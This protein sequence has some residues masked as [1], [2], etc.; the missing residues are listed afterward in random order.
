MIRYSINIIKPLIFCFLLGINLWFFSCSSFEREDPSVYSGGVAITL[1]DQHIDEWVKA[2]SSL[3][4]Y[5]W[6]ATFCISGFDKLSE[7][8]INILLDF[9]DKRH[10][11]AN[12][13]LNHADALKYSDEHSLQEYIDKEVL[14]ATQMMRSAGFEIHSFAYP[15]GSRSAETDSALLPHFTTLRALAWGIKEPSEHYCYYN[16]DPVVYAFTMDSNYEYATEEYILD[17]MEYARD[18]D[19]ILILY[20][21][22]PVFDGEVGYTTDIRLLELICSYAVE[23]NMRFFCL[24]DLVKS[25]IPLSR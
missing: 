4:F 9:Q 19:Q 17:L 12:H 23:N 16:G 25:V 5:N 21:H 18:N 13:S 2:D 11:I 8:S 15:Y 22:K 1:D 6:K 3:S 7:K 14:P 24:K 10:E 20:G